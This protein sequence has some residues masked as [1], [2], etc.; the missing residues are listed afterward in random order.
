M[1]VILKSEPINI[2]DVGKCRAN[3]GLTAAVPPE[4]WL[5]NK[6]VE[7][8]YDEDLSKFLSSDKSDEYKYS[9]INS[10][11][12]NYSR[13]NYDGSKIIRPL[14]IKLGEMN[15]RKFG[16]KALKALARDLGMPV[17]C[18]KMNK[19]ALI[20]QI[21]HI[22]NKFQDEPKI[23][24]TQKLD[25]VGFRGLKGPELINLAIDLGLTMFCSLTRDTI[26]WQ[27]ELVKKYYQDKPC[28]QIYAKRQY[29]PK[30]QKQAYY[31][32][33][34]QYILDY[35][36]RHREFTI[37]DRVHYCDV[38][39]KSFGRKNELANHYGSLNHS[40]MCINSLGKK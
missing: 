22:K 8:R 34:R 7:Y 14:A 38:C 12:T 18:L 39:D 35:Q 16:Q 2:P 30:I 10:L 13:P 28:S 5:S 29:Y 40:K 20:E 21:E 19:D 37:Q 25:G 3:H 27:I 9:I 1:D 24:V 31:K 33:N 26:I 4:D 32:E 11:E 15:F 6:K 17:E 36:R 23:N